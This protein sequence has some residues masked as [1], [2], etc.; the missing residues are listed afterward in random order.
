M[1]K[2][3]QKEHMKHINFDIIFVIFSNNLKLNMYINLA[4]KSRLYNIETTI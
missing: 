4:C 2:L 3:A 1:H